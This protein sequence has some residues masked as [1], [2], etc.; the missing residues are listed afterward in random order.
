M[1]L[2]Q[3]TASRGAVACNSAAPQWSVPA[4]DQTKRFQGKGTASATALFFLSCI[5]G[6]ASILAEAQRVKGWGCAGVDEQTRCFMTDSLQPYNPWESH[7]RVY[8][9]CV[10]HS[11]LSSA[12][13]WY[14]EFNFRHQKHQSDSELFFWGKPGES[15]WKMQKKHL[16]VSPKIKNHGGWL[17]FSDWIVSFL[18]L[19]PWSDLDMCCIFF[20]YCQPETYSSVMRLLFVCFL[21]LATVFDY[22]SLTWC[23][24]N[25]GREIFNTDT[26]QV[27]PT[28]RQ[29]HHSCGQGDLFILTE[30]NTV[31]SPVFHGC[32]C[33]NCWILFLC[34]EYSDVFWFS[35]LF[36]ARKSECAHLKHNK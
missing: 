31:L 4:P 16:P 36:M 11:V 29:L 14:G 26:R 24:W 23:C 2:E 35:F 18:S 5:K 20:F 28:L 34:S 6:R 3:E 10:C 32:G 7:I 1:R 9:C 15:T 33:S 17:Q 12:S 22:E 27:R 25:S 8:I 30:I 21:F 13:S 19:L